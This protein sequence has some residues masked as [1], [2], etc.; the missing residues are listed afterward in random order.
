MSPEQ[1]LSHSITSCKVLMTRYLSGF[2]SLNHT[3]QAPGLPNHV[4]WSL[5]HAALTMHRAAAHFDAE[6]VPQADFSDAPCT[7]AS[8]DPTF[9]FYLESIAFGSTPV[10]D[11]ALYPSFERCIQIYES[12]CDRLAAAVLASTPARLEKTI[13]WGTV[14]LPLLH[15]VPRIIFHNGMHTGQIAD[16]RRALGMPPIFA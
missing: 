15:L 14:E 3:R 12:A 10:D 16:L 7:P 9:C 5:G 2:N 4:G 6:P 11:A 13:M 1:A 8:D